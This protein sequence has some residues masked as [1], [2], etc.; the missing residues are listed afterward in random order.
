MKL[1]GYDQ[2]E[3]TG[4][5]VVIEN[6]FVEVDKNTFS[7]LKFGNLD[8]TITNSIILNTSGN[9]MKMTEY[10]NVTITNSFINGT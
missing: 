5:E 1:S 9:I 3:V 8:V 6:T 2:I 4:N 7:P 10:G